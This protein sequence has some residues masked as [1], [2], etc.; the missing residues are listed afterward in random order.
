MTTP[1]DV[2]YR[3]VCQVLWAKNWSSNETYH[4]FGKCE[5]RFLKLEILRSIEKGQMWWLRLPTRL[6]KRV[7]CLCR[8]PCM[9][10]VTAISWAGV[11]SLLHRHEV[12][13]S[14]AL[15]HISFCTWRTTKDHEGAWRSVKEHELDHDGPWTMDHASVRLKHSFSSSRC[16]GSF[17]PTDPFSF[18]M[19]TGELLCTGRGVPLFRSPFVSPLDD[20]LLI[21]HHHNADH[22]EV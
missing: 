5:I 7:P 22:L 21:M 16:P 14:C 4:L 19:A 11:A 1:I 13:G 12:A 18:A 9:K 8:T 3:K 15:P 17:S 6:G 2:L 10:A 20:S